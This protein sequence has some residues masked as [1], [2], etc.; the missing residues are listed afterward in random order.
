MLFAFKASVSP[1]QVVQIEAAFCQLPAQINLIQS[2]EWGLNNSPENL[3]QGFSHCFFLTFH[4]EAS[5][6]R[7]LTHPAHQ[8]F[9]ATLD[10]A[11]EKALVIDYWTRG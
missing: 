1:A 11:L 10:P 4:D 7:Y 8:A 5:R 6:D 9:V 3:N 2:Y